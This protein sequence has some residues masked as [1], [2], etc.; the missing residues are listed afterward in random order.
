M[1]I[2]WALMLVAYDIRSGV[3]I[4]NLLPQPGGAA[5]DKGELEAGLRPRRELRTL[6]MLASACVASW[7]RDDVWSR[8]IITSPAT[9]SSGIWERVHWAS[10]PL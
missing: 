6:V 5:P 3:L 4:L 2:T 7:L 9:V 8:S 1:A 10:M